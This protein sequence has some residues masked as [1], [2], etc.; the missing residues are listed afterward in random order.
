MDKVI[1]FILLTDVLFCQPVVILRVG[2]S[3]LNGNPKWMF[4]PYDV[5]YHTG[6]YPS[7]LHYSN[8]SNNTWSWRSVCE[9][10]GADTPQPSGSLSRWSGSDWIKPAASSK[11]TA[12]PPRKHKLPC[13][14]IGLLPCLKWP[15]T[16]YVV[17]FWTP[18]V[19]KIKRK[20]HGMAALSLLIWVVEEYR[21][22]QEK[23]DM[24]PTEN[25]L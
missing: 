15:I 10:C 22:A 7:P 20:R 5:H 1:S 21:C 24:T 6:W 25:Q 17:T 16:I 8:S 4:Y 19:R 11:S 12:R 13:F 9:A 14:Q 3:I 23:L 2:P 18:R